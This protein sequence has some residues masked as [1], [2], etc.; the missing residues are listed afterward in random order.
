MATV[1]VISTLTNNMTFTKYAP[2]VAGQIPRALRRIRIFGG[3]NMASLKGFGDMTVDNN[4]VPIWT[5]AGIVTRVDKS[6]IEWLTTENPGFMAFVEGGN[7]K[8]LDSDKEIDHN[9][10]KRIVAAE[11][12]TGDSHAPMRPNDARF[13]KVRIK[14]VDDVDNSRI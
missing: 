5:A 13:G 7:I 3:T 1:T 4:G 14:L 12:A 10:I 6:D 9:R 11:M 2:P 8:V